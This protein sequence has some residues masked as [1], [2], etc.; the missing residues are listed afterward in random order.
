MILL[1][2]KITAIL[3]LGATAVACMRR[4]SAAS[5]HFVLTATLASA[6]LLPVAHAA[7]P[8]LELR[9]LPASALPAAGHVG[10]AAIQSADATPQEGTSPATDQTDRR[11]SADRALGLPW[12]LLLVGSGFA[13][14]LVRSLT[15][16]R[17]RR[18][19][20]SSAVPCP[21]SRLKWAT[22]RIGL[23]VGL[24]RQVNT[25]LSRP[26]TMPATF[27]ALAPKL[28]LPRDANEWSDERLDAVLIH[29]LTHVRR[30]DA[31]SDTVAQA[32]AAIYWYHP[33]VWWLARQARLERER[34][35][36]DAVIRT[37]MRP[38]RYA[39]H[40]LALR[41]ALPIDAQAALPMAQG[42]HMA[43]RLRAIL[44]PRQ[45]REPRS[46]ASAVVALT[47]MAGAVVF[48]AAVVTARVIGDPRAVIAAKAVVPEK[49]TVAASWANLP[50]AE[51]PP[52]VGV[53][54][55]GTPESV[56]NEGEAY[57]RYIESASGVPVGADAVP[58]AD[59]AGLWIADAQKNQAAIDAGVAMPTD[60]GPMR[61]TLT[62]TAVIVAQTQLGR[63]ITY[64][65]A[66]KESTEIWRDQS[67]R[68]RASLRR[69]TLRVETF[70]GRS[71]SHS[72]WNVSGDVLELDTVTVSTTPQQNEVSTRS[73]LFFTRATTSR[74]Q[75]RPGPQPLPA[76]QFGAGAYRPGNGVTDPVRLRE[77]K[78]VYTPA[79]KAAGLHGSV[80]L[81]A[82][83]GI[84]GAVKDVR[85]TRSLDATLGLDANAVDAVRQTPFTPCKRGDVPV[86]CLVVFELHYTLDNDASSQ[87][88]FGVGAYTQAEQPQLV[89]P[90]R[91]RTVQPR[92]TPEAMRAKI[93]GSVTIEGVVG[94]DGAVTE[95][96]VVKSLDRVFGL[97][98]KA[99]EAV[100][101]TPFIPGTLNGVAV[102]VRIIIELTFTLR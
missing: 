101:A 65:L 9:V 82:V 92:Y 33:L 37:G 20:W 75:S 4:T 71:T 23:A 21:E 72:F 81:E 11:V 10:T 97:D 41:H 94:P 8:D 76:G 96:R 35:C 2:L 90:I 63:T 1:L 57:V 84:D 86:P 64:P 102:P 74:L 59:L 67:F 17:A 52:F 14:L 45:A 19:I 22:D 87:A 30:F 88:P 54:K 26:Q 3:V 46:R 27:G 47:L 49:I 98:Q 12:P 15:N 61:V 77:V 62:G 16:I 38:S 13:M 25:R 24:D 28:L 43:Q 39:E 73:S 29:E 42:P 99:M 85:V 79:A 83:I 44:D 68:H 34:A 60:A 69:G 53:N 100:R 66:G 48:G 91:V 80:E 93:E 50:H 56:P 95:A 89:L 51:A 32:A 40:L 58:P 7:L 36:D 31:V 70:G 55:D 6:L 18:V 5:R 78:P